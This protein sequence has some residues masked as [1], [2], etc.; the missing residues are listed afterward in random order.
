MT[1]RTI[2][3]LL[4]AEYFELLSEVTLVVQELETQVRYSVLSLS[5][6]LSPY[7]RLRVTSRV[8]ECQSAIEAL[9]RRQEGGTFD[10]SSPEQYSLTSL[11]DLAGV[12]VLVFPRGRITEIDSV[13]RSKFPVW[14]ADPIPDPGRSDTPLALKYYGYCSSSETVRG[15]LQIVPLLTGLFWEVEHSALYKP[16]PELRG[17]ER[18]LEMRERTGEVLHSLNAF[19]KEFERIVKQRAETDE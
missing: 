6:Q 7:E 2:E 17:I 15:E 19:E 8:K 9:R 13:L 1:Q 3:D 10:R 16:T 18:S 11:N 14:T 4:R 5:L 12:R